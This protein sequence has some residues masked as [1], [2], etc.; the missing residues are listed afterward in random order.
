MTSFHVLGFYT[1]KV[2]VS[3]HLLHLFLYHEIRSRMSVKT[4]IINFTVTLQCK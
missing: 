2:Y 4:L 1:D 3:L